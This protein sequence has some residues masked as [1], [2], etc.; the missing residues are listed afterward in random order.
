[1]EVDQLLRLWGK[2]EPGSK[3][4]EKF[5]PALFHMLDVGFVAQAWLD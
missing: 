4:P 1:M 5:H 3:D 2:T